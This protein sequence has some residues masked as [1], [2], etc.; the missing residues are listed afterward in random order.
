MC[1]QA[2]A[3]LIDSLLSGNTPIGIISSPSTITE[4]TMDILSH[5]IYE[6]LIGKLV[7][8]KHVEGGIPKLVIAQV[9]NITAINRLV[10]DNAVKVILQSHGPLPNISGK[11]T[12]IAVLSL[13]SVYEEVEDEN[14]QP[15]LV[16]STLNTPPSTD[17]LVYEVTQEVLEFLPIEDRFYL[18]TIYGGDLPIPFILKHYGEP[19][20]GGWGEGFSFGIFGK[21]GSGKSVLA[22]MLILGFARHKNMG[23][24]IFDTQGEFSRNAFMDKVGL[25]FQ[26]LAREVKENRF[27]ILS[28]DDIA[29]ESSRTF[30]KLLDKVGFFEDLGVL[31]F[32]KKIML[33]NDLVMNYGNRD[34]SQLKFNDVY[35]FIR[36][37]VRKKY[38]QP[39]PVLKRMDV[40]IAMDKWNL[41]HSLFNKE[42]RTSIKDLVEMFV[43][44]YI[45]I[46]DL[47]RF[48]ETLDALLQM[49]KEEVRAIV[50]REVLDAVI[51]RANELYQDG[52]LTNGLIV[53]EEAHNYVPSYFR[54]S[55]EESIER[56]ELLSLI[57]DRVK[58]T[59]KYGIGWMF[60]TQSTVDF[61]KEV[62]RQLHN[63]IFMYGL[64][65]GADVDNVKSV[66]GADLFEL[67]KTFKDPKRT[68]RYQFIAMGPIVGLS[69]MGMAIA[70]ECFSDINKFLEINNL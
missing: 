19:A 53:V 20:G 50:M 52:I 29:L 5:S 30:F 16:E 22:A 21:S 40:R 3:T 18:G 64:S 35:A 56:R 25:D 13:V 6:P 61:N 15:F 39:E 47:S 60:V 24:I 63:Y 41:V 10:E 31:Q 46:I 67:Y 59:R 65:I 70:I 44:G 55:K 27:E 49:P 43:N 38:R 17:S 14:G 66:L 62:Y 28:L 4:F 69:S 8:F 36:A 11:D 34:P 32:G 42:T 57:K 12:K 58:E 37:W 54:I 1:A 2:S 48:P 45:I 7:M 68:N 9:K 26:S 23:I 51:S 33:I